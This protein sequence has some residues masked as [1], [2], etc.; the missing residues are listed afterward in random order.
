MVS[1][2]DYATPNVLVP[3]RTETINTIFIY[4]QLTLGDY[5]DYAYGVCKYVQTYVGHNVECERFAN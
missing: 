1:L 3:Q 2:L 4:E 5:N